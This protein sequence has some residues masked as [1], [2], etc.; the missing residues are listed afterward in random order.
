[1]EMEDSFDLRHEPKTPFEEYNLVLGI[2]SKSF[3]SSYSDVRGPEDNSS[4]KRD[5]IKNES[6]MEVYSGTS[7][8]KRRR[9]NSWWS[10][11]QDKMECCYG[12]DSR[13]G[14]SIGINCPGN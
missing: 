11:M 14:E 5:G 2:N 10:S 6:N 1:M 13:C 9:D 12:I 8:G 4:M 7:L 3:E